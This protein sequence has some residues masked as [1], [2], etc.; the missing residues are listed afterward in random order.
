MSL[1]SRN[2]TW[3]APEHARAALG[4][5]RDYPRDDWG[6]PLRETGKEL[7]LDPRPQIMIEEKKKYEPP[8][9][10]QVRTA[11]NSQSDGYDRKTGRWSFAP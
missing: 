10:R 3:I 11:Y 5:R 8:R 7:V 2:K 1:S 4:M 6:V 9:K